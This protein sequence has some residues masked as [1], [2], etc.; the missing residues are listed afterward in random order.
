MSQAITAR[1]P[2]RAF[3]LKFLII[4]IAM[5]IADVMRRNAEPPFPIDPLR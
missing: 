2:M 3:N 1:P 5:L 4:G